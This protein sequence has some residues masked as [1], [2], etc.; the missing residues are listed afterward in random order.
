MFAATADSL[1]D[2]VTAGTA[3][4]PAA[5][6]SRLASGRLALTVTGV[7]AG[8]TAQI[9]IDGPA[10]YSAAATATT[11]FTG[12]A[13]GSYRLHGSAVTV[14][15]NRFGPVFS[16]DS[17]VVAA[18]DVPVPVGAE[19]RIE[20]G[21]LAVTVAG[22]PDGNAAAVT[23]T[24]P[25]GFTQAVGGT[26]TLRG[27]E[28]GTYTLA[29]AD[30][31]V[32]AAR[33]LGAPRSQQ[34]TVSAATVPSAAA[35]TYSLGVGSLAVAISGLPGGLPAAVTVTGP[36]GFSAV[37]T[38]SA[39][40]DDLPPGSYTLTA[41]PV[42]D[43]GQVYAGV[44]AS[45]TLA[46]AINSVASGAVSYGPTRG[47]LDVIIGGLPGGVAAA[48]TVT[49]PGGFS[50]TVTA[51]ATLTALLPGSYTVAAGSVAAGGQTYGAAPASQVA[52][53][54]V[55]NVAAAAVTY[56][57]TLGGLV[58]SVTGLPGGTSAAVTVTGPG[59]FTHPVT[60]TESLTGLAAGTYTVAASNVTSAGYLYRAAPGTQTAV[61][62][63]ASTVSRSVAYS[64]TGKLTITV[65]GLPGGTPAAIT[66][67]GPGGFSQVSR[68]P[69]RSRTWSRARIPL[70]R[71]RRATG[72]RPLRRVRRLR[73]SRSAAPPPRAGRWRIQRL[74]A[75]SP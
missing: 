24:G 71:Q 70:P 63:A 23:V 27:L 37:L 6:D 29:A 31:T 43:G 68:P 62:V 50:E 57:G 48:V 39:T 18:S 53:V 51:S 33:Y 16:A 74:R 40:I 65:S 15:G 30:V 25:G 67:T 35:V 10:G 75:A 3:P 49:G 44:P 42:S 19:Y 22:L 12:L 14:A 64:A 52:D 34:A 56:A 36:G 41:A 13:P 20:T 66:V 38:A 47:S 7:P 46:V 28:P 59:G 69:R 2:G 55:G 1:L 17:V 73:R 11:L 5:V 8:Q 54:S 58:V 26:D 61:V 72:P 60:A 9:T 32:G 4:A 21:S 45:Q